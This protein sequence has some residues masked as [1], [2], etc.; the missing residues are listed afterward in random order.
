MVGLAVRWALLLLVAC[1]PSLPVT[2]VTDVHY[3]RGD[4]GAGLVVTEMISADSIRYDVP[5][6]NGTYQRT[7]K[8]VGLTGSW[9]PLGLAFDSIGN[10]YVTEVG[11]KQHRI[12][13]LDPHAASI[14]I[15]VKK[16]GL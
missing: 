3:E 4:C 11:G 13:V 6:Q 12:L 5:M 15:F 14:R 8:P 10:L 16:K 9:A 7:F 1:G 2:I